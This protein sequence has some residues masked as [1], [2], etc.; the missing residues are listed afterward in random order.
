MW[1][2]FF[3]KGNVLALLSFLAILLKKEETIPEKDFALLSL[4]R[5][6]SGQTFSWPFDINEIA[7]MEK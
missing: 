4:L 7:E 2:L 6:K 1:S 5:C 3:S